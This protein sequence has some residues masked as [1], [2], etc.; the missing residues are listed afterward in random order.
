MKSFLRF[1]ELLGAARAAADLSRMG[2]HEEAM[3]L[4]R[5]MQDTSR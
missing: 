4:M 5:D 1:I 2:Y 3:R